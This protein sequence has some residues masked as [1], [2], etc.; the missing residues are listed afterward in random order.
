MITTRGRERSRLRR[1]MKTLGCWKLVFFSW[2]G[3][4]KRFTTI[5]DSSMFLYVCFFFFFFLQFL[6]NVK[7][8]FI[9]ILVYQRVKELL[10][11]QNKEK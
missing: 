10:R 2:V 11:K 6:K 9:A 3:V 1:K 4:G 5:Y 8:V 7:N